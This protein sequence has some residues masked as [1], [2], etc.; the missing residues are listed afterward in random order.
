[1][2]T[3]DF[4]LNDVAVHSKTARNQ[5]IPV[6]NVKYEPFSQWR[7]HLKYETRQK[8][9]PRPDPEDPSIPGFARTIDDKDD[10][11]GKQMEISDRIVAIVTKMAAFSAKHASVWEFSSETSRK[12]TRGCKK[13]RSRLNEYVFLKVF[14]NLNHIVFNF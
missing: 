10:D 4:V 9:S 8:I 3:S 12:M 14:K 7:A 2:R 13:N 5:V 6:L 1:M 11:N